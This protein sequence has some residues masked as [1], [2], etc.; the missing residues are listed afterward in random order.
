MAHVVCAVV[1]P[2]NRFL[3]ALAVCHSLNLSRVLAFL[4][5]ETVAEGKLHDEIHVISTE[6]EYANRLT[7][8]RVTK[9]KR[10]LEEDA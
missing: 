6:F 7:L 4:Q 9:Q 3:V 8:A 1:E 2:F 10:S 5:F